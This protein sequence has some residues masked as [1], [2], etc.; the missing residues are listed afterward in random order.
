MPLLVSSH[1]VSHPT[2]VTRATPDVFGDPEL[3]ESFVNPDSPSDSSSEEGKK[4]RKGEAAVGAT[5]TEA[6]KARQLEAIAQLHAVL[7]PF[8]LRRLKKEVEVGLPPK[9]ELVVYCPLSPLQKRTY[10]AILRDNLE[11]VQAESSSTAT[12][13]GLKLLNVVMQLRKACNHPYHPPHLVTPPLS[14]FRP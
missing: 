13:G 7:K 1:H 5:T 8:I 4:G 12:S 11:L 2:P 6:R 9:T 10:G 3:F 14:L